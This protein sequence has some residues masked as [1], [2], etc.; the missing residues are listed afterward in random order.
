HKQDPYRHLVT[1]SAGI[2]S[3]IFGKELDYWQQHAYPSDA[4]GTVTSVDAN[5]LDRPFFYGEVGPEPK[6]KDEAA[7]LHR[8]LWASLMSETGG[9]A[10]WWAWE[11]VEK[12]DLYA[13][14]RGASE[15]VK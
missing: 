15:F 14:F 1:S 7:W 9:A 6:P 2:A 10:Q 11:A 13:E 12:N 4:A 5:K 8:A 3:A